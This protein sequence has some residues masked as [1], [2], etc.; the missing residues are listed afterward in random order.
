MGPRIVNPV[1]VNG[2]GI[3][4]RFD[5]RDYWGYTLIDTSDPKFELF[6]TLSDDDIGFATKK[7]DR[8]GNPPMSV[9]ENFIVQPNKLKPEGV[10]RDEK[11]ARLAWA[12]INRRVWTRMT[13]W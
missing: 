6:N 3:L 12:W 13:T 4:Y 1:D 8:N 11:F 10:T 5:I 7:V 9:F 2:K